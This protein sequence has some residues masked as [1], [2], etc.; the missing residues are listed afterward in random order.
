MRRFSVQALS[1]VLISFSVLG[2]AEGA[3][4]GLQPAP[5]A[6]QLTGSAGKVA[7]CEDNVLYNSVYELQIGECAQRLRLEALLWY[8]VVVSTAHSNAHE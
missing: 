3:E 8:L 6:Y 5:D 1:K 7:G 2:V 4:V